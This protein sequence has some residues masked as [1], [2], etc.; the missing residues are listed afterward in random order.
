MTSGLSLLGSGLTVTEEAN[1]TNMTIGSTTVTGGTNAYYLYNNN[2]VL[3][4]KLISSAEIIAA[5][6][7]TPASA[8]AVLMQD[9]TVSAPGMSF[10]SDV[11]TGFFQTVPGDGT[12]NITAGGLQVVSVASTGYLVFDQI[13]KGN[14]SLGWPT[15]TDGTDN[16]LFFVSAGPGTN[17]LGVQHTDAAGISAYVGRGADGYEHFAL[18]YGN[19]G[20]GSP[21][22]LCSFWEGSNFP[23]DGRG[24]AATPPTMKIVQTG[25]NSIAGGYQSSLRLVW[26]D[27]FLTHFYNGNN[28]IATTMDATGQWT[29]IDG[30]ALL[31]SLSNLGDTNTGIYFPSADAVGIAGGGKLA[32]Q[33]DGPGSSG[34]YFESESNNTAII[35]VKG[36]T[37][38]MALNLR[39]YNQAGVEL[40]SDKGVG[41]I[42][43]FSCDTNPT[44]YL[45]FVNGN[46]GVNSRIGVSGAN[47]VLGSGSVLATNA[48]ANF[49]LVPGVGGTPTGA[50]TAAGTGA[51]PLVVDTT[52]HKLY[53]YSG[54][55]WRDAGP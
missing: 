47:L 18:G 52:N 42:A 49:I 4:N 48:T 17:V 16:E 1:A 32:W 45:T 28:V 26:T 19:T 9:G 5:L 24:V 21:W 10:S 35:S 46:S 41:Y 14:A 39:G 38:S 54:G 6:G 34:Y 20:S 27:D 40:L 7:Y 53:F 43:R 33:F 50:P 3:G 12:L 2:G 44:T 23:Q 29:F 36:S 25:Y 51:V 8:G 13:G 55:S 30:T 37:G 31:P 22:A 15:R 11:D